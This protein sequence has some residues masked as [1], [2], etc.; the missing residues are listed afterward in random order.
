V[1]FL[2]AAFRVLPV[3]RLLTFF[4]L[5]SFLCWKLGMNCSATQAYAQPGQPIAQ[6]T[7][8]QQPGQMHTTTTTHVHHAGHTTMVVSAAPMMSLM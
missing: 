5:V 8:V 4:C 1:V 3:V 6:A 7:Y 2:R